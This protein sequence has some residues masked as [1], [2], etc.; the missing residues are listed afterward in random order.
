MSL[1][2]KIKRSFRK[3]F[4]KPR[5][6]IDKS[7]I[8]LYI[9]L[10]F[11]FIVALIMRLTPVFYAEAEIHALDPYVQFRCVN[12]IL[13]NGF[14]S[15]M[16]WHDDLSW[17][18]YGK[19]MWRSLYPGTPLSG[20]T[21]YYLLNFIGIPVTILQACVITPAIIGALTVVLM[22]FLG[23]VIANKKVGILAAL[24]LMVMP[25][26]MQR[27]YA[28]FFDNE[29]LGIFSIVATLLF[30]AHSLKKGSILTGI[31]GG[32]SLGILGCTWGSW[33]YVYALLS[34]FAFI[35]VL[36]RKYS[37]RLLMSFSLTIGIGWII[38]MMAPRN[39]IGVLDG[40]YAII[41]LAILGLLFFIELWGRFK[42]SKFY[43][44]GNLKEKINYKKLLIY[45]G[46]GILVIVIVLSSTGLLQS[47]MNILN[48]SEFIRG[49]GNRVLAI[50][51]PLYVSQATRSV[52]EHIPSAWGTYYYNFSF[53]LLLLPV[54]IFFFF[55]RFR[56][57]D[58]LMIIFG[59]TMVY[60]A[61]SYVRLQ[62]LLAP[63][64][65]IVGAFG[66]VS[67][68]RPFSLIFKEKF[69]IGRRKKRLS[70]IV[71]REISIGIIAF[72][73]WL[74][75]YPTVHGIWMSW[76]SLG[77]SP[78]IIDDMEEGYTWMRTTIPQGT[79]V[80]SWWD[81]GYRITTLGEK[82]SVDDN[83]TSNS[84]QM[85]MVGRMFMSTNETTAIE[86]CRRY[87][88][89][90]V[91]VR[92]GYYQSGLAGDDGKWQWM[93]RIASQTLDDTKYYIDVGSIWSESEYKVTEKFF[94]TV[95][96]KM[97]VTNEP[98]VDD[99]RTYSTSDGGTISGAEIINNGGFYRPFWTRLT[100]P[101][102]NEQ[103][104]TVEGNDWDYYNPDPMGQTT[105]IPI[106]DTYVTGIDTFP[107]D[108]DSNDMLSY[109]DSAF[110][111]RYRIMKVYKVNYEKA[112]LNF[113]IT[114]VQLY[115]NSAAYITVNNTGERPFNINEIK[116]GSE[117]SEENIKIEGNGTNE[118]ENISPGKS[119]LI[120]STGL[121]NINYN[122]TYNVEV[123]VTDSEI[124]DN[125]ITVE[126][127]TTAQLAP[128]YNM[129]I[130][131]NNIFLFN[132]NSITFEVQNT[133]DDYFSINKLKL[134]SFSGDTFQT[135]DSNIIAPGESKRFLLNTTNMDPEPNMSVGNIY[136]NL[137]IKTDTPSN[138][139][140]SFYNLTVIS[141]TY[142]AK[143]VNFAALANE[144]IH[145][146]I[147]N[148]GLHAVKI[149]NVKI[150]G[151]IWNN[152]ITPNPHN[153][154]V[155]KN[156]S[157]SFNFKASHTV[158]NL[159]DSDVI[160]VNISLVLPV[161]QTTD[162][163]STK[164]YGN[165]VVTNDWTNYNIT[166]Q[167]VLAFSNETIFA[168][169]TNT[170][171]KNLT[172][173]NFKIAVN[174]FQVE[175]NNFSAVGESNKLYSSE[176]KLFKIYSNLNLNFTDLINL[177]V[178]TYQGAWATPESS[179]LVQKT[180]N[181][182]IGWTEA[183]QYNDT[184]FFNLTNHGPNQIIVKNIY[185]NG[186]AAQSFNPINEFQEILP[187][188][189]N[190][191]SPN[192]T[193]MFKA[194]IKSDQM[195]EITPGGQLLLNVTAWE[196]A[197]DQKQVSWAYNMN[198]TNIY[199]YL[200]D[201]VYITVNNSG[202]GGSIT[203]NNFL[204]NGTAINWTILSGSST[205]DIGEK[206]EI[207][208]NTTDI[209]D[210]EFA[211]LINVTCTANFSLSGNNISYS[212]DD[213]FV[214]DINSNITII[215]GFPQTYAFD[216]G[217]L[218]DGND[219]VYITVMN[220]GSENITIANVTINNMLTNFTVDG[221]D[222][223]NLTLI[224][225]Q[226]IILNSSSLEFN[227]NAT[228]R[229]HINVSTNSTVD[230]QVLSDYADVLVCYTN[231]NITL[232]YANNESWV[233]GATD[234]I[235]LN[236]T[237]YG[238]ESISM[239][240]GDIIINE[241]VDFMDNYYSQFGISSILLNPGESIMINIVLTN[242]GPFTHPSPDTGE[243]VKVEFTWEEDDIFLNVL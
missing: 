102:D 105:T 71:G 174:E 242:L 226:T 86:I 126:R 103:Y 40:T 22:Y 148:N 53:M 3:I 17:V 234:R 96:W 238:N 134:D 191:L 218:A 133:G 197:S 129:S 165:Y 149:D 221:L 228:E 217:T 93:L 26:H 74:L 76:S 25:G 62:L 85:G 152:Y 123:K 220:T 61:S 1:T 60:F 28:G 75:I 64:I 235:Y 97:L 67:L 47:F 108:T 15:F 31:L 215:E 10:I 39:G 209:I 21:V 65:A 127:Q 172:I 180:G 162:D 211:D 214:L 138:L 57:E 190:T 88:V 196:G 48:Q 117:S 29:A 206:T 227:I 87:N 195:D 208:L 153:Y 44:L 233:N 219:T 89:S 45:S 179:S 155:P 30:F 223:N 139:S 177:T 5:I 4:H 173:S 78:G 128:T 176:S 68:I 163:Q 167:D 111:S 7:N 83:A 69:I 80:M 210:L 124:S 192:I 66:L 41:S 204:I 224:P 147:E 119:I 110:Y 104:K 63:A 73:I 113:K 36:I 213:I 161:N 90:Y 46:L 199:A 12:Y 236:I 132:N 125:T 158:L 14:F 23:K 131:K 38:T 27:T 56:E 135:N 33:S 188:L 216:N 100:N 136:E 146:D 168:N 19:D 187:D 230:S 91:M 43:F 160:T 114:D 18:P 201:S 115:N 77:Q 169:L 11:I 106:G 202:S 20:I 13:D 95:L 2:R 229:I 35:L 122:Q 84:T 225:Y 9:T 159:N 182:S 118:L 151:L 145:F 166:V 194:V 120:R 186:E 240:H 150:N 94:D 8:L 72:F 200:N 112:D 203:I 54:G 237:N 32:L 49:F 178:N 193:Q 142:S 239:G 42:K 212:R 81:Y 55:K 175:I 121:G 37:T 6:D 170:G 143:I 154:L 189:Y 144:T 232:L 231:F 198:F 52:A 205:L 34:L 58:I 207:F 243:K 140:L 98:Y 51:N 184:V 183:Y 16:N 156:S 222:P 130:S 59:I 171:I 70:K 109:F 116:I 99:E 24:F 185:F 101:N 157:R 137:T 50:I 79:V 82:A 107:G 181:V 141:H 164:L 92:W 241:T